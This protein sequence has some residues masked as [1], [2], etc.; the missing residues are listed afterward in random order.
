M[1]NYNFKYGA[2]DRK[3]GEGSTL[4]EKAPGWYKA[5]AVKTCTQRGQCAREAGAGREDEE[6]C[7]GG[8][9]GGVGSGSHVTTEL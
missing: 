6:L 1:F 7:Q 4:G 2:E 5:S 3:N 8:N 9:R